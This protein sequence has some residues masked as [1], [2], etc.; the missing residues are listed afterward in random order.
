MHREVIRG[1]IIIIT[2][3]IIIVTP[4]LLL[5]LQPRAVKHLLSARRFS[6]AVPMTVLTMLR[7]SARAGLSLIS[8]YQL[9]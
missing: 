7:E 1:I 4:L 6:D 8:G 5:L 9:N 3:I 2:I